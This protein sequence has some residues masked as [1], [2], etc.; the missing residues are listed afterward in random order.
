[1]LFACLAV[2]VWCIWEVFKYANKDDLPSPLEQLRFL[3]AM[4]VGF[5]VALVILY[6]LFV[7][8]ASLWAR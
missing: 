8:V 6:R 5:L 1:M 3:F 2:F 4:A 7:C